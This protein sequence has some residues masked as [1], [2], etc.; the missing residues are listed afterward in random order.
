M[1]TDALPAIFLLLLTSF[2]LVSTV[3]A[4]ADVYSF[5]DSEGIIHFTNVPSDTRYRVFLRTTRPLVRTWPVSSDVQR[6]NPIIQTVCRQFGMD[7]DLVRAVIKAESNF[8]H[9][10]VSPKGAQGLM[11]LTPQTAQEMAVFDPFDPTQNIL[12]GVKYLKQLLGL[13]DGN[14]PLALAAYNAGPDRVTERKQIP[15]IKETQD[16]VQ[17]V[18]RYLQHYKKKHGYQGDNV[19]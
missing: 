19:L 3:P 9:L 14:I 15:M 13:F 10:A 7:T 5:V 4:S 2:L 16:Y 12:G 8:N 18:L 11:Q 1:R 6:Y 17:K